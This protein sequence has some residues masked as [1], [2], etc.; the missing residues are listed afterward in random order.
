[1]GSL[2]FRYFLLACV[3]RCN[4][5]VLSASALDIAFVDYHLSQFVSSSGLT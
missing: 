1:M 5:T 3:L 2:F 4:P